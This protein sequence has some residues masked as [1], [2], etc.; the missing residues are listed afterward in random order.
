MTLRTGLG[1]PLEGV[2][3]AHLQIPPGQ[4]VKAAWV[5]RATRLCC[6]SEEGA[7]WAKPLDSGQHVL[8]RA[9]GDRACSSQRTC[10]R[11]PSCTVPV[12]S[13]FCCI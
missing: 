7:E 12:L 1:V 10:V 5:L 13:L 4:A 8:S 6:G 2:S 9:R 3:Q 11:T